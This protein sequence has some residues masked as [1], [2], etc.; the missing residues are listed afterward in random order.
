MSQVQSPKL[1]IRSIPTGSGSAHQRG[2]SRRFHVLPPG[3]ALDD[4]E[5]LHWQL[6]EAVPTGAEE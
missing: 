2:P 3:I 1:G 4:Q 5:Q 6:L